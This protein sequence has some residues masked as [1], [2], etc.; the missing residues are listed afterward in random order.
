[1]AQPL[2]NQQ[3][4]RCSFLGWIVL[5]AFSVTGQESGPLVKEISEKVLAA[6]QASDALMPHYSWTTRSEVMKGKEVLNILIEKNQ[7]GPDG[8]IIS[9]TLNEQGAKMPTAFLI[10]DIAEEEKASIEKFLYGLRD[11]LHQYSFPDA[12]QACRFMETA[13]F[14]KPDT[15]KEFIFIGKNVVLPDDNMKWWID[16]ELYN[17]T[18]TEVMTTFEGDEIHFTATFI[19]LRNGLTYMGYAEMLIPAK[20][21]TLQIQNYDYTPE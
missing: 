20:N 11:F 5:S 2:I 18:K 17:T 19:T 3:L 14:Q 10:K 16:G 9:K 6:R 13:T 21:M 7:Y 15:V 12:S 4:L 1:M 8:K